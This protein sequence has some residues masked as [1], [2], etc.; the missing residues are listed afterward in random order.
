M[1]R[2][3]SWRVGMTGRLADVRRGRAG[4]LVPGGAVTALG[5]ALLSAA[6]TAA[7]AAPRPA[8]PVREVRQLE[9]G[10][11][12]RPASVAFAPSPGRFYVAPADRR[13][14]SSRVALVDSFG[15]SASSAQLGIRAA[16]LELAFDA[17]RRA[18]VAFDGS[19]GK[20]TT[21]ATRRSG[22]PARVLSR[23]RVSRLAG[24]RAAGVAVDRSSG[25][26]FVL[27]RTSGRI[28][29]V[30]ARLWRTRGGSGRGRQVSWIYLARL[31]E[32]DLRGLAFDA[33]RR[34]FSVLEL[35]SR[36]IYE[37]DRDGALLRRLDLRTVHLN[38][39]QGLV[40][41]PSGDRT[42]GPAATSL[43]IVDA[44]SRKGR[45]ARIVEVAEVPFVASL[46]ATSLSSSLVNT[47]ETWR[48]S[49]QSPDPSGLTYDPATN[50]LL[51]VD[52]EVEEMSIYK[53][54][55]YY[56]ST[57]AG[58]LVRT[59]HTRAWSD[60]PV[61]TAFNSAGR[62]FVSDDD[63]RRVF[64]IAL[65]AD[66]RFDATDPVATSFSTSSFG[67]GDPEG[68]TYDK[69]G[70]RLF[71]A[72][73][74]N[75]EIYEVRP[76]DGVFGNGNDQVVHFD[77]KG[78]GI[79]DPEA[80]EFI[81]E[82]GTLYTIGDVGTR[83][84]EVTTSGSLVAEID[85]S[86]A[87]PDRAAGMAWAPRS[88][89]PAK[90]SL[91]IC[92]RK[93]DNDGHPTENDGAIYELA[94]GAGA[95]GSPSGDV[96]IAASSDDAEEKPSGSMDLTSSD[97]ELVTDGTA[98]QT[99]GLR[100]PGLAVPQGA[101]VTNAYIQFV[102]DE[103]QSE[104]T[105][106]TIKAQAADNAA[107]FTT[108]AFNVSSRPRT[109][110]SVAWSPAAW[111]AGAAAAAQ[112]TPNLAAVVQ[113]VVNRPGWASGN[114][115]AFIVTG[116]GHRTAVSFN[117]AAARAPVLHVEVSGGGG[118]GGGGG[119]NQAP[120]VNAGPDQTIAFPASASLDGTVSDDGQPNPTPTTVWSKVSG[121]GTVTFAD[122]AAVDTQASFSAA[123]TYVLRLSADD[124]ALTASDDVTIVVNAPGAATVEVRLPTGSDDSE[125]R[126][127]GSI[128]LASSD[129]EFVTDGTTVQTVGM[130]FPGIAVPQ[131]AAI[132]NAYIQFVADEAQSEATTLTIKAQAADNAST[133]TTATFNISSRPRTSA[134][135]GWSPAAWTVGA[136]GAAQRTPNL[137]A[138]VQEVV[139]RPGWASGNALAFI[140]TGSGHR[141]AESAEGSPAQAALLHIEYG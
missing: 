137:A 60:E 2:A 135:A 108:G 65:G 14:G 114:A 90:K 24:I 39:P 131:G 3:A 55:N 72:D 1:R 125:E 27:D 115:L 18:L 52:G 28:A 130:R 59:S 83:V 109:S 101:T 124:G 37:Y 138:L 107:T 82:T 100:F 128:D 61:G 53:G 36:A 70:N 13:S 33:A 17:S 86:E 5:L 102:A 54:A 26:L 68:I 69:A 63:Q 29:A 111:T 95:G 118:G 47:I 96:R 35:N 79:L 10:Q 64:E 23:V 84:V 34:R 19:T 66:G 116:S 40:R 12:R 89:D 58:S 77:T 112:R 127:S 67:S 92:D 85:T 94:I 99:V 123:G 15:E 38:D 134:S 48:W 9:T 43:Y 141:T 122:A 98:V 31:A 119:G 133:F 120:S 81:P 74:V 136:A 22:R 11:I 6:G 105:A 30:P 121:P 97:L 8:I 50:R 42:D 44:A 20:V 46:A 106:L 80:V 104:A 56:E 132:A 113:E 126:P 87:P 21:I 49:P 88:T 7:P 41:A 62:L 57:L 51:V 75:A 129:L 78:L 93:V 32:V 91:Y 25:T 45:S 16:G 103:A 73:G 140:V 71:I 117:G 139:N 76:V 4:R 110:A